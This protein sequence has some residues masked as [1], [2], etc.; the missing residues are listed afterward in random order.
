VYKSLLASSGFHIAIII[1]SV[2]TLPFLAKKPI[3]VPPLI[4]VELIQ[5]SDTTNI[6]FAPKAAK[7]IDKVKKKKEKLLS[8]Q[9]PPKK[10]K[11]E[12]IKETKLDPKKDKIKTDTIKKVNLDKQKDDIEK[13]KSKKTPT[14]ENKK[15]IAKK[16]NIEAIPMPDKKKE[17]MVNKE[18]KEQQPSKEKNKNLVKED[19]KIKPEKKLKDD[20]I[21]KEFA[22]TKKP[23]KIDEKVMQVS[24]FEKK[25]LFDPNKIKG[26]IDKQSEELGQVKKKTKGFTQSDDPTMLS[27]DKLTISQI[28]YVKSQ[29]YACW[30]VPAG[31]PLNDTF[32]LT[33][34]LNLKKNGEY[35]KIDVLERERMGI[36][37]RFKAFADSV[38]RAI[39]LCNPLKKLPTATYEKWKVMVLRFSPLEMQGS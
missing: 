22:K 5:V 14:P 1:I 39:R 34:K 31:L 2:F 19:K 28:D 12:K 3:D 18:E 30:A 29:Y 36:D 13:L 11:K 21:I 33:V 24:E 35:E 8:E 27:V 9:A 38:I 25:E 37:K 32:L 23:A 6:P 10:V 17:K 26:L 20:K 16:E 15:E 4:S 7:I